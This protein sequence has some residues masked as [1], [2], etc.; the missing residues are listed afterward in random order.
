MPIWTKPPSDTQEVTFLLFPQFSNLCLANAVEPLRAANDLLMR[1]IYRWS[2]VTLDG[3]AVASSS[4]L[5]ILP[6]AR[7]VDHPGGD[8]LFVVSSYDVRGHAH[9][10]TRQ[11]LTSAARRFHTVAGLDTGAW[12]MADA[13]LLEDRRATI[14]PAESVAFS[15]AFGTID[16][17]TDRVIFDGSRITCGGAMAT[18]ACVLEVIRRTH[19]EALRLDVSQLFLEQSET[20]APN[21]DATGLIDQALGLMRETVE[22]PLPLPKLARQL[23]VSGRTLSRAFHTA[24]GAAPGTVYRRLRLANVRD[25]AETGRYPISEIA[26]RCGYGDASAMTRAFVREFGKPPSVLRRRPAT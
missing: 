1:D 21:R 18:F 13:G 10:D 5:P 16:V 6:S 19:G 4:G 9:A 17:A 11:A 15:E 26:L 22:S 23:G 3:E 24:V 14:H 12:L 8:L 2:F 20:L 7:L 25:L